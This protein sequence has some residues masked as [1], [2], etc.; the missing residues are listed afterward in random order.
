MRLFNH[1]FLALL[2]VFTVA[3]V[4]LYSQTT[5]KIAGV[6]RDD[7]GELLIGA[8]IEVEGTQL[9]SGTDENGQY[10]ILNVPVGT[11]SVKCTYVGYDAQV[12]SNIGV[13]V[14]ITSTVDFSLSSGGVVLDTTVIIAKRKT[15]DNGSGKIIGTEFIENTGI[16]GIE[17]IVAKTSG[18]VQDEKGQNI[19]IRGGRNGETQI[20]IDGVVTNNPLDRTST[21][22]VSNGALQELSVLTGGFSAEY[23]NVLSGVINVTTRSAQSNYSGSVE[24]V[25]DVVAGDYINTKSQG[26]N[27]Y[28]VSLGG[29]VIPTK[30][31]GK[32]WSLYGSYEKTFSLVDQPVSTSVAELWSEDGIL[33]NFSRGGQAYT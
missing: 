2:L 16:R 1:F 5:G 17:N 29:P 21:A 14:G 10:A 3:V 9:R 32:Y 11:Y 26:Y 7:K 31:L 6:V 25:S 24:L 30:K 22:S 33:P 4:N 15:I 27:V 8:R 13:S 23:G 12:Q 18:V 20:I 28:S 19:N